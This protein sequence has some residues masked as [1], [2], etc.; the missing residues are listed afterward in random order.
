MPII[1]RIKE[2]ADRLKVT[3]AQVS[4]AWLL[5]KPNLSSPVCGC[6]N[7]KISQ[8]EDLCK[9]VKIKLSVDDIKYL[10]KLYQPHALIGAIP[11]TQDS[12]FYVARK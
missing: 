9:A 8:L 2:I 10:D 7:A 1:K 6:R 11:K 3:M 4:I 5:S 12:K